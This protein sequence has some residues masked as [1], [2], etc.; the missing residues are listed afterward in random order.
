MSPV[1][2]SMCLLILYETFFR[3][4]QDYAEINSHK[5]R[6]K[7]FLQDLFREVEYMA[8]LEVPGESEMR[9]KS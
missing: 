4:H 1:L 3:Q 8:V 9:H 5:Q 2:P 7:L 6:M